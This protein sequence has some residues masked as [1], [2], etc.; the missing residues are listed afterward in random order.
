MTITTFRV[1]RN[2][3]EAARFYLQN[4]RNIDFFS[5]N[6]N[7]NNENNSSLGY[8]CRNDFTVLNKFN[9]NRVSILSFKKHAPADRLFTLTLVYRNQSIHMQ[10]FFQIL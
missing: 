7:N 8:G 2:T 6:F 5:I 4:N 3:N 9:K 1:Y 10:D